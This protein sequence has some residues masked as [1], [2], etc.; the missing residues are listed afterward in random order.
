MPSLRARPNSAAASPATTQMPGTWTSPA[1][2]TVLNVLARSPFWRPRERLTAT[3]MSR[4]SAAE[5]AR[6]MTVW[7][8]YQARRSVAVDSTTSAWPEASS[9]LSRS[10]EAMV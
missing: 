8:A 6:A 1:G 7:L 3:D 4:S 2:T 9:E 5:P 10:T